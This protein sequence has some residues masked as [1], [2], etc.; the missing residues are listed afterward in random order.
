LFG[1]VFGVRTVTEV[2]DAALLR[3]V[4]AYIGEAEKQG[5]F[6]Q[7]VGGAWFSGEVRD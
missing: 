2:L 6:S 4:M 3:D 5:A 7:S 1:G